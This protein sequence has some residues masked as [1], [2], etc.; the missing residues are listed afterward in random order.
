MRDGYGA[1]ARAYT[2]DLEARLAAAR[3]ASGFK[4]PDGNGGDGGDAEDDSSDRAS[5][6]GHDA[7]GG[8]PQQQRAVRH[9]A[10]IACPCSMD[11]A[12]NS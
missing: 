7:T 10:C 3:K 6:D 2:R 12:G 8:S 4:V 9:P 11:G 1:R 5:T